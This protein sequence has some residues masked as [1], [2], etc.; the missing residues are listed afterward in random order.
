MK[1]KGILKYHRSINRISLFFLINVCKVGYKKKDRFLGINHFEINL[2]DHKKKNKINSF[3]LEL[4]VL[5]T[6]R[7]KGEIV[8]LN[9]SK[10][11]K[12]E[13]LFNSKL[14]FL[15]NSIVFCHDSLPFF[16]SKMSIQCEILKLEYIFKKF[17]RS[18]KIFIEE[19]LNMRK[20]HKLK[21]LPNLRINNWIRKTRQ[22]FV[23]NGFIEFINFFFYQSYRPFFYGFLK[24]FN[25]IRINPGPEFRFNFRF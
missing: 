9:S 13:F 24:N 19:S 14:F 2:N 17:H 15:K 7:P 25:F 1:N 12:E 6:F 20:Y 8:F 16:K 11:E 21:N 23:S 3:E 5:P 18:E 4:L 22:N 10:K